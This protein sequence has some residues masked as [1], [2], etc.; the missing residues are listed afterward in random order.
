M[1]KWIENWYQSI[2]NGG[3]EHMYGIT[4]DM[5][6][7]PGW[8]VSID[9]IDTYLEDVEFNKVRQYNDDNDWF[10]CEKKDGKFIGCGDASKLEVI[11]GIFKEWA[12]SVD[13][14]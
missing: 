10:I 12:E 4:I 1:L 2:C 7:N 8:D 9:I 6:D 5:L 3:W 14:D 13:I 11:L